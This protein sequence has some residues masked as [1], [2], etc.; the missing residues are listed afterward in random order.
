ME[1]QIKKLESQVE[2]LTKAMDGMTKSLNIVINTMMH[3]NFIT[4][5]KP[6][7]GEDI[8]TEDTEPKEEEKK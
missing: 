2:S 8:Q 4:M 3:F 6:E 5:K 1:D 7:E